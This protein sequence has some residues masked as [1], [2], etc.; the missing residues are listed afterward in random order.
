MVESL[1]LHIFTKHKFTQALSFIHAEFEAQETH[2]MEKKH[3]FAVLGKKPH[4]PKPAA[5]F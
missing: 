2:R 5:E 1:F 4:I 3:L